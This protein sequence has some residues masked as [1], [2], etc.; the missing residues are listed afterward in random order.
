MKDNGYDRLTDHPLKRGILTDSFLEILIPYPMV[1]HIQDECFERLQCTYV[2]TK[3]QFHSTDIDTM[4]FFRSSHEYSI[5]SDLV[6]SINNH[7]PYA[8]FHLSVTKLNIFFVT[9]INGRKGLFNSFW[10]IEYLF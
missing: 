6:L 3:V 1:T 9:M 8:S 10:N 7:R 4:T 5:Q 2:L